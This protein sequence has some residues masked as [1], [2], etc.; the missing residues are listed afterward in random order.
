MG[1]EFVF[2]R[3][4]KID[5]EIIILDLSGKFYYLLPLPLL[6]IHPRSPFVDAPMIFN[7]TPEEFYT[8][9]AEM[10]S[11][12]IIKVTRKTILSPNPSNNYHIR[13]T[14]HSSC[15]LLNYWTPA[16]LYLSAEM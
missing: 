5:Y 9:M 1:E 11:P 14:T 4:I 7:S 15:C 13:P 12:R 10:P 2:N 16:K 6:I 3:F 8:K